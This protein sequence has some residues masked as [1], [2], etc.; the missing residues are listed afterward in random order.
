M[1][2]DN[3]PMWFA[4]LL[5]AA[6]A[7][8]SITWAQQLP[9]TRRETLSVIAIALL[10]MGTVWIVNRLHLAR[11]RLSR[12]LREQALQTERMRGL[13][14]LEAIVSGSSDLLLA[15]DLDGRYL[16]ANEQAAR[17]SGV[18]A[19]Q[20]VGS[21]DHLLFPPDEARAL[22]SRDL[23]VIR[24]MRVSTH[25]CKVTTVDGE[26]IHQS[27]VGPLIDADGAIFGTYCVARDIT[28]DR[29][30][31]S[32]LADSETRLRLALTSAPMG[33]WEWEMRT[34]K[35]YVSPECREILK[36]A[37]SASHINDMVLLIHPDDT[38][39]AAGELADAIAARRTLHSEYRIRRADGSTIWVASY[40][41]IEFDDQ[42]RVP[43]RMIGLIEDIDQRVQQ[44]LRLEEQTAALHE[45]SAM[46]RIG[47]W[48]VCPAT[49]EGVWTPETARI[50]DLP[51][52]SP[53][54]GKITTR[55][56]PRDDQD[57]LAS[58]VK[59]ALQHDKAFDIEVAITTVRQRRKW[60]RLRGV[61]RHEPG[62]PMRLAGF[63]QDI[64]DRKLAELALRE[65][66]SLTRQT[67]DTMAEGLLHIDASGRYVL[68]NRAAE[69]ILGV[70]RTQLLGES[71]ADV[72]LPTLQIDTP[73]D[74]GGRVRT[75][76][77]DPEATRQP[78]LANAPTP[79]SS[80]PFAQPFARLR[81]GAAELRDLQF[82]IGPDGPGQR[83][84]SVNAQRLVDDDG[85][86]AG[87][88]ATFADVTE[89]RRIA[90]ELH[91]HRLHLEE[92]VA[93][94]T[95]QLADARYKA[96][97]ASRAKT[98]F[99]ANMSHEIRT[100]MNAIVGMAR[101]LA[102]DRT[103]AERQQ[104]I[105]RIDEASQQLL[106]IIDDVLDLSRIESG[107][108]RLESIDFE[109]RAV[110]DYVASIIGPLAEAKQLRLEIDAGDVPRW[111]R[112]DPTRLS[113]ALLNL[114]GNAVK[115]TSSGSVSLRAHLHEGS[116]SSTPDP[117]R[118][119]T[120][121]FEV[122]DT[123]I[124][125]SSQDLPHVFEPFEQADASTTRHFGGSGLGLA[126]TRRLAHLMGGELG[127]DSEPGKGSRFW[128]RVQLLP[129]SAF[130][131]AASDTID[132]DAEARLSAQ[133]RG[134]RVL[135]GED[136][137]V[138][139]QVAV[140]QLEAVGLRVDI[141]VDGLD[142][143]AKFSRRAY[144]LILV[145]MQMP[146]MD[147]LAATR[148]IR[149]REAA[150]DKAGSDPGERASTARTPI[151]AMTANV[152]ARDRAA[153]AQAGMNDFLAKPID[154]PTLYRA[155]LRWL[156]SGPLPPESLASPGQE[157][158]ECSS[159]VALLSGIERFD[160]ERA[161]ETVRHREAALAAMLREFVRSCSAAPAAIRQ[162][163]ETGNQ[164]GLSRQLHDLKGCLAPVG[165]V[166]LGARIESVWGTLR[167]GRDASNELH[168]VADELQSLLG[169]IATALARS[170]R[171]AAA[172]SSPQ[173]LLVSSVAATVPDA[174]SLANDAANGL[175][176]A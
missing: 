8:L 91:R 33:V 68:V 168:D 165:A 173:D 48:E 117:Q 18:T 151:I 93:N 112:G 77:P 72:Q 171:S 12:T 47:G 55:G 172:T 59:T 70:D 23:E 7:A 78:L 170:G 50:Y 67:I 167:A 152:F 87:I 39:R 16:F 150:A 120:V 126:I 41:R 143:V 9:E 132:A 34:D 11:Q 158:E 160:T 75:Q 121:C 74:E 115:F 10:A 155:L 81:D 111:L 29:K 144:A 27:T 52:G 141:A 14:L 37:E 134:R 22:R 28:D 124:G 176:N 58:A 56:L 19:E 57:L 83:R 61:P 1:L 62:T 125:I 148:A 64:T 131:P 45:L 38:S 108:L 60:V 137:P 113:Q 138:S 88:V 157:V 97:A 145:D 103:G 163:L 82:R 63:I 175:L 140:E 136:H 46:A 17:D 114:A 100:P 156:P 123:G 174:Q 98:E 105:A 139:R 86:F 35:A 102:R 142:L 4:W 49:R 42:T 127:A 107:R 54:H 65:R 71:H 149:Q 101:L 135:L 36:L 118:A 128:M 73:P 146:Q 53:T 13:R 25:D 166:E 84:L 32:A 162:Y 66:E 159:L 119:I 116:V 15:K 109:L 80:A 104:R 79:A 96:E 133:H 44:R 85:E 153:C 20:M 51:P 122:E 169:S 130:H 110:F 90:S 30:A 154:A 31:A 106:S 43:I 92:L 21:D 164:E 3:L 76:G 40:G 99:L 89:R 26:R 94:R 161:L 2:S 129:G 5:I 24:T 69:S 147:G 6:A 95:A